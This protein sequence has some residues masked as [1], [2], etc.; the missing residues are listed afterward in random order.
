[1]SDLRE[2]MN[3]ASIE[4]KELWFEFENQFQTKARISF[5]YLYSKQ[6]MY[7]QQVGEWRNQLQEDVQDYMNIQA[8]LSQLQDPYQFLNF[9]EQREELVGMTFE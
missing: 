4:V 9:K 6:F 3:D 7:D 2:Y 8:Y 1:M 5:N